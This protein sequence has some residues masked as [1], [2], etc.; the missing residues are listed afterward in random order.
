MKWWNQNNPREFK[1]HSLKFMWTFKNN[2]NHALQ[3]I[4]NVNSRPDGFFFLDFLGAPPYPCS[5]LSEKTSVRVSITAVRPWGCP[6]CQECASLTGV[7][8]SMKTL[9][10]PWLSQLPMNSDTGKGPR[11][12]RSPP[13]IIYQYQGFRRIRLH[14]GLR[15]TS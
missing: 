9:D 15:I 5:L 4:L 8:T 3:T 6:T 13:P 11:K 14:C 10:S 2:F 7:V 1:N 12:L